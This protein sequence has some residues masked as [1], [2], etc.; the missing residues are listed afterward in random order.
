MIWIRNC[1][2]CDYLC[3]RR[4]CYEQ[5]SSTIL[6]NR[7]RAPNGSHRNLKRLYNVINIINGL[8]FLASLYKNPV[9]VFSLEKIRAPVGICPST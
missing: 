8:N 2:N 7:M 6:L 4:R 3:H 1:D 9:F 5:R